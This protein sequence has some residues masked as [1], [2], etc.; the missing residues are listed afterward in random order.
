[1]WWDG[2]MWPGMM[3][4]PLVMLGFFVVCMVMMMGMMRGSGMRVPPWRG[5]D[6]TVSTPLDI[7]RD[8][9]ARG[10]ID[11]QEYEQRKRVLSQP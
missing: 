2:S 8:R 7:L 3:L 6:G 10:E 11:E 5:R 1:M 9:F 4:W